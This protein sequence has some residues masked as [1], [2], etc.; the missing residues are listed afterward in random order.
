MNFFLLCRTAFCCVFIGLLS[1]A[2]ASGAEQN[3]GKE[4]PVT[5]EVS[6][7]RTSMNE[8]ALLRLREQAAQAAGA[9]PVPSDLLDRIASAAPHPR[10]LMNDALAKTV[11]DRIASDATAG[12][13]FA[14]LREDGDTVMK[15]P[16]SEFQKQG[17]RLLS[18]SRE[19]LRRILY[20]SFLYRM[21][22][23]PGYATRALAEAEAAAAFPGWNPTHFL[24]VA[25]MTT[26]LAIAYDWLHSE[27]SEDQEALLRNAILDMGIAPSYLTRH[28]WVRGH[29][30][31]NQVCHG[32]MVLG[33]LALAEHEPDL[34]A[35]VIVRALDGLPYAM[36]TYEPDG[37]YVE[38]PSY[39]EY[40]TEYNALLIEALETALGSD[41]GLSDAEGFRKSGAFPLY[42]TGPMGLQFNF[43][44]CGQRSGPYIGPYWFARRWQDPGILWFE[45]QW[46]QKLIR[47]EASGRSRFFPLLLI[48][49]A[50]ETF[51]PPGQPLHWKGEGKNPVAVH[52]SSWTDPNAVFLAIKAGT[53]SA[54]HG[55]MDI[56][57]FVLEADGVRWAVD[58]G[59]ES[60][61]ALEARNLDIWNV[62]QHSDRWRIFRYHNISHNTLTVNGEEQVVH[63]AAA[64]TRFSDAAAF[65]HTVMDMSPVYADQLSRTERGFALLPSGRVLIQDEITAPDK[66]AQVRWAMNTPGEPQ[67][68]NGNYAL[69]VQKD[70]RLHVEVL[71]PENATLEI[72]STEPP[73]EWDSTNPGTR[74]IGFQIEL[75]ASESATLTVLL[76]PGSAEESTRPEP[77]PL[78]AWPDKS[79]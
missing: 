70:K 75:G 54:P 43:A 14:L 21:T 6:P 78:S 11:R 39:W 49:R 65:P 72:Y 41:F 34:A 57:S 10:L 35:H 29:N 38:G 40:G 50:F 16:P 36:R 19:V 13:L 47:K 24:D 31:W 9:L 77:I 69:L 76:T 45:E 18:V 74:Q 55:H 30:N 73:N 64:I 8:E 5:D 61:G 12:A 26:A 20:L 68:M 4:E 17:R 60:Y 3:S 56:G 58:F 48:Y 51:S 37:V 27:L 25:E 42:M 66:A 52:R 7:P 2:L 63:A 32:G 62:R 22:D 28:G 33:A 67:Q 15:R 53:P 23:E 79:E 46:V 44:D 59:M 71:S 1:T